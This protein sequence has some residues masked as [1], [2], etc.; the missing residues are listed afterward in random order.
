MECRHHKSYNNLTINNARTL[1]INPGV[2]VEFQGHYK[3]NV[4]GR[5]LAQGTAQNRIIFTAKDSVLTY[6]SGGWGGIRFLETPSS[7]DTSKIEFCIMQFGNAFGSYWL[8]G[9]GSALC[10]YNMNKLIVA[11]NLITRNNNEAIYCYQASPRIEGNLIVKNYWIGISCD[12]SSPKITNNTISDNQVSGI[13]INYSLSEISNCIVSGNGQANLDPYNSTPKI[14]NCDIVGAQLQADGNIDVDPLFVGS[15]ANP[16]ALQNTSPCINMGDPNFTN[17]SLITNYDFEGNERIQYGRIDIG[18]YEYQGPELYTY[19]QEI[20]INENQN[21]N[22]IL[23]TVDAY[24]YGNGILEFSVFDGNDDN[25]IKLDSE[26][27]QISIIDSSY[28]NFERNDSLYAIIKIYDG[29]SSKLIGYNIKINDV[30][31]RVLTNNLQELID[32]N[33]L[34][35]S[36]VDTILISDEDYNDTHVFSIVQANPSGAFGVVDS[37]GVIYVMDSSLINYEENQN[38][39]LYVQVSDGEFVDT[40][41]VNIQIDNVNELICNPY[42]QLEIEENLPN[43]SIIYQLEAF[44]EDNDALNYTIV[45][46]NIS[47]VFDLNSTTGA[48]QIKNTQYLSYELNK[49]FNLK[50][51]VSDGQLIDSVKVD[52]DLID[53]NE[54]PHLSDLVLNIPENPNNSTILDTL[55]AADEDFNS[56]L[57]YSII[58][59][60]L[61]KVFGVIDSTGVVY[62]IDSTAINFEENK[63][64]ELLTLVSDGEL[65]DTAAITINIL[66]INESIEF[67]DTEFS[68]LENQQNGTIIGSVVASDLDGDVLAHAIISGNLYNTFAI[69]ASTGGISVN[70]NLF[71]DYEVNPSFNLQVV[72][73]DGEFSDTATIT[74][75]LIDVDETGINP[76]RG[77][78]RSSAVSFTIDNTVYVGLGENADSV[79][80]DFWKYNAGTDVWTKVAPFPGAAR[81]EAVAFAV[82]G[83]GYV[84]LGGSK[85]PFTYYPDFYEYNPATNQWTTLGNF[86]GTARYDAVSFVINDT[87]YVGTGADAM[88]ETKDFWKYDAVH[89][90][91][92][93]IATFTGAKRTSACAFVVEGK[94]YVSGGVNY[95]NGTSQSSDIQEYNPATNSWQQKIFADGLHLSV[96]DATAIGIGNKG[97]ICYGNKKDIVSYKPSTN[98]V[99]NLGDL[100]NLGN[101]RN[102]PISFALGD[103]VYF[104]TGYYGFMTATYTN[105]I[106]SLYLPINYPPTDIQLSFASFAE[107]LP[108]L[109][110]ISTLSTIDKNSNDSFT[111]E[112]VV[113]EGSD[114]NTYF[115]IEGNQ[116]KA[117]TQNFEAK[118]ELKIRVKTIDSEGD[119]FEKGFVLTV[120][121]M[122]DPI[123][124]IGYIGYTIYENMP[125]NTVVANLQVFDEDS[126]GNH[127]F[128]LVDGIGSDDNNAFSIDGYNLLS[129]AE[130]NYEFKSKLYYRIKAIDEGNSSME[131]SFEV[132]INN[133]NE[134][135]TDILLSNDTVFVSDMLGTVVGVLNVEDEDMNDS[136]T[137]EFTSDTQTNLDDTKNYTITGHNL[138]VNK[139]ITTDKQLHELLI[140]ASDLGGLTITCFFAIL[141]KNDLGIKLLVE[142]SEAFNIYPNPVR[143]FLHIKALNPVTKVQQVKVLDATG[144]IVFSNESVNLTKG[145]N[146]SRLTTGNYFVVIAT[147][148]KIYYK[149]ISIE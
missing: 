127:S 92:S 39:S 85:Y 136:H 58:H 54:K 9:Y 71:L 120:T 16:Y 69:N 52:I 12:F 131:R 139:T 103:S 24:Y 13:Q 119:S 100:L 2:Y 83:K 93:E 42:K 66:N 80:S 17:D 60:S 105:D 115:T 50:I 99:E 147:A 106:Q 90:S 63:T 73:F 23:D 138:V 77:I 82:N 130:F 111:Y 41:F 142:A 40:S 44:D 101:N 114:D 137:F 28:F 116:L 19:N 51:L 89:D 113:G 1:T 75:N 143:G 108:D 10:V 140:K 98:Q 59:A 25:A 64:F 31:E 86:A 74:I 65:S 84:G 32:E 81:T 87:A 112:L 70:N 22:Q 141:V 149:K 35:N 95:S 124:E 133:V 8:D 134:A 3:L 67:L 110:A 6:I 27:G 53:L 148:E 4:Q 43:D 128:E 29:S 145:I 126:Q 91:W 96:N 26:T 15:G 76:F 56:K 20:Q 5:I 122:N 37:T 146:L 68:V 30:N 88:D 72:A 14:T 109:S 121:D 135:P 49:S 123:T 11:N 104:G 36:I 118:N 21:N 97:Y 107:N 38:F 7:N 18:A 48:I 61:D 132:I 34:N 57:T 33:P 45:S 125:L 55:V 79:L 102:N 62:V 47:N 94:G 144:K 117:Y 129:G 78:P 46:G